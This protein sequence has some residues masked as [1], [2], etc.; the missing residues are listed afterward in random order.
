MVGFERNVP[1]ALPE[2]FQEHI[3]AD[4]IHKRAEAVSLANAI[5][6]PEQTDYPNECLLLQVVDSFRRQITGAELNLDELG[7]IRN[8]MVF[9]RSVTFPEPTHIGLVERKKFQH[10]PRSAG[11]YSRSLG[12]AGNCGADMGRKIVVNREANIY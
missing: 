9:R 3:V 2:V 12:K 7:E 10:F 4:G 6:G 5:W 8:K 11:K 1:R